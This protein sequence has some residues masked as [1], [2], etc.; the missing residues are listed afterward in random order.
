MVAGALLA[1]SSRFDLARTLVH[2]GLEWDRVVN[3]LT[4]PTV[5]SSVAY[6]RRI[7]DGIV[8]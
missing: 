2:N 7:R 6:D 5:E 8:P 1:G 4:R 3:S